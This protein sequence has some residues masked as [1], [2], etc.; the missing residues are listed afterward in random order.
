MHGC[1]SWQ[2]HLEQ[3]SS[4]LK[5]GQ[6]VW[7]EEKTESYAF[8]DADA[9]P[10]FHPAGPTLMHFRDLNIPKTDKIAKEAWN[11]IIKDKT[12]LPTPSIK[13]YDVYGN[14]EG[15]RSFTST[16][17]M[18]NTQDHTTPFQELT[19][20]FEN[21]DNAHATTTPLHSRITNMSTPHQSTH[22][23]EAKTLFTD[24]SPLNCY[25]IQSAN[26]RKGIVTGS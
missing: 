1:Q 3:I 7:W 16:Q 24:N 23:I 18:E 20:E 17:H 13:I 19:E 4:F 12:P 10:D 25:D 5:R 15:T 26:V 22:A 14:Y 6:G 8:H 9:D 2:A 11:D 21:L